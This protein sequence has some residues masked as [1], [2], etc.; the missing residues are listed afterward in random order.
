MTRRGDLIAAG[1]ALVIV[2]VACLAAWLILNAG[3]WTR[4]MPSPPPPPPEPEYALELVNAV[5]RYY[6]D[7][8]E[9]PPYLLGGWSG[10]L[11][12]EDPLIAAGL[13]KEYPYPPEL[14]KGYEEAP[15]ERIRNVVS[16]PNDPVEKLIRERQLP[17]ALSMAKLYEAGQYPIGKAGRT[18]PPSF[19]SGLVAEIATCKRLLCAGGDP[20]GGP[21]VWID[22]AYKVVSFTGVAGSGAKGFA[23]GNILVNDQ[24]GYQRGDSIEAIEGTPHEV[25][26]WFYVDSAF[27][28]AIMDY[29]IAADI[30]FR[31]IGLDLVDREKGLIQPDGLPDGIVLL[32]KL[33]DGKVVEVVKKYD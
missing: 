12:L 30:P 1:A 7:H 24:F 17:F 19:S 9:Y 22:N 4:P 23:V 33:K 2:V 29:W 21:L 8:G 20:S 10:E 3:N 15:Q 6:A 26:L 11:G 28:S 13:L 25:W 27:D 18:D 5:N 32:Y 31:N 16:S 14:G